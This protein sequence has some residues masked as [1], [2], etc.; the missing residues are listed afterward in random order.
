[1]LLEN[2]KN[3]YLEFV[4][5]NLAKRTFDCY[6]SHLNFMFNYFQE[7][8]I[9]HACD[10]NKKT[11]CKF[12]CDSHLRNNSNRTINLRIQILKNM[13]KENNVEN[14][15]LFDIKKLREEKNTF[16]ALSNK[17][18]NSILD[19]IQSD[20]LKEKNKL[21]LFVLIDTGIRINELLNIKIKNINFSNNTILLTN[22]KSHQ[23]RK[24]IFS[25]YVGAMMQDYILNNQLN[26][27]L[28]EMTYSGVIAVF[29]RIEKKLNLN[30]FHPHML[31]HTF[32]SRLHK[33]GATVFEIKNLLGHSS[34]AITERYIHF[35]LDDLIDKFH[36][37]NIY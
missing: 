12:V 29:N 2:M 27:N 26:D 17:E 1:M 7:N 23:P 20:V 34:V 6:I 30:N 21:M 37:T 19:Y 4:N 31:R 5:I 13:F 32:A 36:K 18:L 22:T 33:N 28:F 35:D 3:T 24:V 11:L 25:D 10:I 9:I 8:S 14:A 15:D 16:G